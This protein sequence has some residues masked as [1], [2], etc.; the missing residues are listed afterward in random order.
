MRLPWAILLLAIALPA[1]AE[2]V[3]VGKASRSIFSA[4]DENAYY[5]DPATIAKDGDFRRVW[6]IHDLKEKG[7]QGERSILAS[8]EY[9]CSGK[10]RRTLKAT[11]RSLR[12]AQGAIVQLRGYHDDWIPLRPGKEDEPFLRILDRLCAS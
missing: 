8:V 9:D 3:E 6:E 11:G 10:R 4:F 2:W 7:P 1:R 12:M 5:I